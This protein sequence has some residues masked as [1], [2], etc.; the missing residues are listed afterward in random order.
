[1]EPLLDSTRVFSTATAVPSHRVEQQE[2]KEFARRLFAGK[3]RDLERH[4][5]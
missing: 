1:M 4:M 5:P 2:L 3:F